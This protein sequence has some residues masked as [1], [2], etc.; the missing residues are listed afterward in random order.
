MIAKSAI[1]V[2]I[3]EKDSGKRRQANKL[4]KRGLLDQEEALG[5]VLSDRFKLVFPSNEK[6]ARDLAKRANQKAPNKKEKAQWKEVARS[7]RE[8]ARAGNAAEDA[9]LEAGKAAFE[10][11]TAAYTRA[12]V[13]LKALSRG[14]SISPPIPPPTLCHTAAA[15]VAAIATAHG[16]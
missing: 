15:A 6:H 3:G 16:C 9:V 1:I 8:A 10:E 4:S 12:E 13:D 5:W 7:A 14:E 11:A 2:I